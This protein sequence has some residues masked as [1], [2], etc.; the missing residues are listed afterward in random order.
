MPKEIE[1]PAEDVPPVVRIY[2]LNLNQHW[3]KISEELKKL[4][5]DHDENKENKKTPQPTWTPFEFPHPQRQLNLRWHKWN[6]TQEETAKPKC[7]V[8]SQTQNQSLCN[9]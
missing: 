4:V 3:T 2:T 5:N 7:M 9:D 6:Q 1:P 8:A